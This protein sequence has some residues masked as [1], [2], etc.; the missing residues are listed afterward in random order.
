MTGL[1]VSLIESSIMA[2]LLTM[3]IMHLLGRIEGARGDGVTFFP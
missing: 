2:A 1:P 3:P